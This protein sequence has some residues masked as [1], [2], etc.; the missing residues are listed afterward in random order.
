MSNTSTSLRL[1]ST[2]LLSFA[3]PTGESTTTNALDVLDSP[4]GPANDNEVPENATAKLSLTP[5][6]HRL[7][8]RSF[9]MASGAL[10]L[11]ATAGLLSGCGEAGISQDS[12][13]ATRLTTDMAGRE[14]EIPATVSKVYSTGQPGV[15]AL[16]MLAPEKLLGWCMKPSAAESEY[17]LP[18]YLDLPVYGLMQGQNNTANREVIVEQAPDFILLMT[19]L[20]H[21][22]Y[23]QEATEDAAAIERAMNIPVVVVDYSLNTAGQALRYLGELLG[24]P[25]RAEELAAY[26]EDVYTDALAK[27]ATIPE[28]SRVTVYY[29]QGQTGLQTAPQGSS[30]S[31]VIDLVGGDNVAKLDFG[32][33]GRVN[34][35]MEQVL[36]W[37]PQ[38]VITSYA[39]SHNVDGDEVFRLIEEGN[40]SWAEITAIQERRVYNTPSYPYNWQDMPPSINRFMG[41]TWLGNLL[42]PK[43]FV[44]DIRQKTKEFYRLFYQIELSEEQVDKLLRN[45]VAR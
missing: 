42:Y 29:A 41:I 31:E 16:Y 17:L 26:C 19:A 43:V 44:C 9:L 13:P 28:D 37:N 11:G 40:R 35:D 5:T 7:T 38:V 30:H 4:V 2:S 18:D 6:P 15:V 8:R 45:A 36:L 14:V 1:L 23:R 3:G 10:L 27:A 12:A 22:S 24:S 33:G 20:A 39:M 32:S 34:V 25:E 21:D